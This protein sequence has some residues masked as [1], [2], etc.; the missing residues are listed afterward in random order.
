MLLQGFSVYL[1]QAGDNLRKI[2][3]Y[4]FPF[5]HVLYVGNV[6]LVAR[7]LPGRLKGDGAP[8]SGYAILSQEN[9]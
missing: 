2:S 6:L 5:F 3:R 9:I 1:H 7:F 8:V 4:A